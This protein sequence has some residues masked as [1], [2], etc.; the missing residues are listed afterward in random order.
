MKR[1]MIAILL[2]LSLFLAACAQQAEE[3]TGDTGPTVPGEPSAQ[4]EEE[5]ELPEQI[6]DKISRFNDQNSYSFY[7]TS[8]ERGQITDK[9]SVRDNK[10]M[11][12]VHEDSAYRPENRITNVYLD[13]TAQTAVGYC[14]LE[15]EYNCVNQSVPRPASYSEWSIPWPEQWMNY[16]PASAEARGSEQIS[17]RTTTK[18]TFQKDG[19][20]WEIWLD[21]Y[22]GLPVR[23]YEKQDGELVDEHHYRDLGINTV[24]E[25]QVTP[26]Q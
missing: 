12:E 21:S 22:S 19:S 14:E 3:P 5:P 17:D 20:D 13:K 7:Y 10:A 18:V 2:V 8:S 16:I 9:Y 25:D 1:T 26:P 4:P 6:Q 11:I 23:V 24:T 15:Q